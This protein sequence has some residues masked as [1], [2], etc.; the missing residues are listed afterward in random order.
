MYFKGKRWVDGMGG[1]RDGLVEVAWFAMGWQNSWHFL[2]IELDLVCILD[3]GWPWGGRW[4]ERWG[5]TFLNIFKPLT[6]P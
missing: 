1:E 6:W 2:G 3:M 5:H 4:G